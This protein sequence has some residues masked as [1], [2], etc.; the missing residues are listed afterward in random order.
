MVICL[1][2]VP[3]VAATHREA[4]ARPPDRGYTSAAGAPTAITSPRAFRTD[5]PCSYLR[6]IPD[7]NAAA[8]RAHQLVDLPVEVPV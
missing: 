5:S 7:P 8:Q 1:I 2:D 3:I 4:M 6:T